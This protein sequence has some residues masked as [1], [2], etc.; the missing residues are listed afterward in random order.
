[1]DRTIALYRSIADPLPRKK[2]GK[3]ELFRRLDAVERNTVAL[4]RF[5]IVVFHRK[6]TI[7][8]GVYLKRNLLLGIRYEKNAVL[9]EAITPAPGV[10]VPVFILPCPGFRAF[11]FGVCN[12]H[13]SNIVMDEQTYAAAFK[14]NLTDPHALD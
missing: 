10:A 14:I 9:H 12:R 5:R 13:G 3:V 6:G 8:Y 7:A 2:I 11:R 4:F 1:M